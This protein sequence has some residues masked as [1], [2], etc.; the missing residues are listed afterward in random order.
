MQSILSNI[1]GSLVL[2]IGSIYYAR[3]ALKDEEKIYKPKYILSIILLTT[4]YTIV[5]LNCEGGIRSIINFIVYVAV[6]RR[7]FNISVSKAIL[8]TFIYSIILIV[9]DLITLF[10]AVDVVGISKEY[11]YNKFAGTALAN[12]V[13][14]SGFALLTFIGQ[15]HLQRLFRHKLESSIVNVIYSIGTFTCVVVVFYK[16]I[17]I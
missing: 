6:Y 15:K 4:V 1:I 12:I 8:L 16:I 9:P 14:C 2:S 10:V 13:V 17:E 5:F 7:L 3:I 11:Y